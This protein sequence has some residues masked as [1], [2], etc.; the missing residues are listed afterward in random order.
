MQGGSF[1][2]LHCVDDLEIVLVEWFSALLV[3]LRDTRVVPLL[4][5]DCTFMFFPTCFARPMCLS[6]VYGFVGASAG[7]FVNAFFFSLGAWVLFSPRKVC[8]LLKK[9]FETA[10]IYPHISRHE[11]FFPCHYH[12]FLLKVLLSF[13]MTH[14]LL[15]FDVYELAKLFVHFGLR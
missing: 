10:E 5:I 3:V 1:F 13:S 14:K 12:I 8:L 2:V 15:K 11:I 9:R 4:F 7:V 6:Y